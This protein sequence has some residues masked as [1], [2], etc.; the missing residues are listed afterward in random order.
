MHLFIF[1]LMFL[2]LVS[3][4]AIS[5]RIGITFKSLKKRIKDKR[6]KILSDLLS[7]NSFIMVLIGVVILGGTIARFL[8]YPQELSIM[9]VLCMNLIVTLLFSFMQFFFYWFVYI[10][11]GISH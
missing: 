7:I 5:I 6:T 10:K 4:I 3:S 8:S 11:N 9:P 2:L 1:T